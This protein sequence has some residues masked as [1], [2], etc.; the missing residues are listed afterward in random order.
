M[1]VTQLRREEKCC[2][3]DGKNTGTMRMGPITISILGY[4]LSVVHVLVLTCVCACVCMWPQ[5]GATSWEAPAADG[6]GVAVE[7]EVIPPGWEKVLDE[8]S[9]AYYYFKVETGES[10]WCVRCVGIIFG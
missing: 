4:V 3:L 8:A 1:Y 10:S 5:T 6:T 9:G 7:E 2:L